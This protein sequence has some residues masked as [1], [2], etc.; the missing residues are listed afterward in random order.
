MEFLNVIY[1]Q[2]LWCAL[3][4]WVL[5]QIGK[6]ILMSIR[7]KSFKREYI[8]TAGGM[9]STHAAVVAA[10]AF[11][12]GRTMGFDSA[13]FA[14][15]CITAAIVDYDAAG[16]RYNAGRH[17]IAINELIEK[18]DIKELESVRKKALRE[19]LGHTVPQV[20]VGTALGI[21]WAAIYPF[22]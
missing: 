4:T 10:L 9:P 14:I 19:K 21:L 8:C 17:A 20:L 6:I 7:E 3:S 12:V 22:L 15:A 5:V 16:V 2:V 11:A 18:L 13:S 1:N